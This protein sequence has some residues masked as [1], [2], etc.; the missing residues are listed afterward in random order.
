M[1]EWL[2]YVIDL[3][4]MLYEY[5]L[6]VSLGLDPLCAGALAHPVTLSWLYLHLF[7]KALWCLTD[8][9]RLVRCDNSSASQ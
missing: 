9:T 4:D 5:C 7:N 1:S 8:T 6:L 2:G 3:E